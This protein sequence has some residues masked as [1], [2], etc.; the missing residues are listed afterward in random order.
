MR[1]RERPNRQ[2]APSSWNDPH[3]CARKTSGR[4]ESTIGA[5]LDDQRTSW[6]N[7]ARRYYSEPTIAAGAAAAAI[8]GV[9]KGASAKDARILGHRAAVD[10]GGE[11]RCRSDR[12]APTMALCVLLVLFFVPASLIGLSANPAPA[13]FV[14]LAVSGAAPVLAFICLQRVRESSCFFVSQIAVGRCDWQGK[15]VFS[16]LRSKVTSVRLQSGSLW[17]GMFMRGGRSSTATMAISGGRLVST[18]LDWWTDARFKEF[19]R[20]AGIAVSE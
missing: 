17:P 13:G 8:G 4:G 20:V 16:E 18:D 3:E 9:E 2:R 11:Y 15:V 12:A 6:E 5:R 19:T 7:W 1:V 14:F 10:A